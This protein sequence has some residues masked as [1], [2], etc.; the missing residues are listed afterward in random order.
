[1]GQPQAPRGRCAD[2][3]R[4]AQPPAHGGGGSE[5]APGKQA[6]TDFDLLDGDAAH[7]LVRCTL[8]TGRTHQIRVHM[9]SLGHP[10]IADTLYGGQPEGGLERQA[11]HAFRLAFEHPVTKKPLVHYAPLPQDMAGALDL[12]GLRYNLPE[13]L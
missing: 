11:L 2:R 9:A 6:R 7:S 8:H 10:L 13:S 4:P 3:P 5:S 12:W 1:M